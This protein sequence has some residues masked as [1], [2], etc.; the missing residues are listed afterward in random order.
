[1]Q[2][3][4]LRLLLRLGLGRRGGLSGRVREPRRSQQPNDDAGENAENEFFHGDDGA[5]GRAA[6]ARPARCG[7]EICKASS[8]WPAAATAA[9]SA[10]RIKVSAVANS[11]PASC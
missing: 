11:T 1:M 4:I 8:S 5:V 10:S 2:R 7:K 3:I 6:S 9:F